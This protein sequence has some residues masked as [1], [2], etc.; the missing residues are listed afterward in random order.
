MLRVPKCYSNV[1]KYTITKVL[2]V[3][4]LNTQKYLS[5]VLNYCPGLTDIQPKLKP[6]NKRLLGKF[7]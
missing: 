2:Q 5:T 4:S 1:L 3:F 6:G 7:T